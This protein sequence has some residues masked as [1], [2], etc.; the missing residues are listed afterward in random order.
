LLDFVP[1]GVEEALREAITTVE[2]IARHLS[3]N[4]RAF[5]TVCQ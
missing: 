2:E 4:A 3:A 5:A 1:D